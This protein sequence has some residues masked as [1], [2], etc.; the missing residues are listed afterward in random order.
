MTELHLLTSPEFDPPAC[1]FEGQGEMN[2]AKTKAK[3]FRY[4]PDT[5]RMWINKGQYFGPIPPNVFEH[6][7]GGYQVCDKWL[8]DRK[9]RRLELKD[10]QTYCRMVTAIWKTIEIQKELDT[11][12]PDVEKDLVTISAE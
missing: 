7:I 2:V 6:R 4:E 5:Q 11:L 3:G 1:R 8:K 12:Y 10:I 9:E